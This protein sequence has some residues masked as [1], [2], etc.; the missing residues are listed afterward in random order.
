MLWRLNDFATIV[1]F[2]LASVFALANFGLIF[3]FSL[4]C[5]YAFLSIRFGDMSIL[6]YMKNAF[7]FCVLTQQLFY[8]KGDTR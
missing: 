1:L 3:P 8:W 6:D 2:L 4:T 5:C 7:N